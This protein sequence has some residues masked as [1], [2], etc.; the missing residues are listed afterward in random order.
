MEVGKKCLDGLYDGWVRTGEFTQLVEAVSADKVP[1]F[2]TRIVAI[3]KRIQGIREAAAYDPEK[4]IAPKELWPLHKA[5]EL[6]AWFEERRNL[7]ARRDLFRTVT[8]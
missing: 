3:V 8:D 2:V 4:L 7:D 1:W 5:D 6:N